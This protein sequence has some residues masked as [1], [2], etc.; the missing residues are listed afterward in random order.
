MPA[1]NS[2]KFISESIESV[3]NQ[4]YIFWELIVVDDGSTDRTGQIIQSYIKQ[5]SRIKYFFQ[6]N[7]KQGKARNLGLKFAQGELIAFIDSDDIWLKSKLEI[8]LLEIKMTNSTMVFSRSFCF[9]SSEY[10]FENVFGDYVGYMKGR[11]GTTVLLERNRIPILSVLVRKDALLEVGGFS[12]DF[13]ISNAEDYHLWLKLILNNKIFYGS[14]RILC[15]YR[16][17]E[18]SVT[19]EDR[20]SKK[21]L[22]FVYYDLKL[23]FPSFQKLINT[24]FK[25]SLIEY[26][27][28]CIY[29]KG[30][31]INIIPLLK[32]SFSSRVKLSIFKLVVNL[33]IGLSKRLLLLFYH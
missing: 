12:E 5:D 1:Y 13:N 3:I 25:T 23:N 17:S 2:E 22:P 19:K 31:L 6:K 10:N 4:S 24:R 8:Q 20:L 33:P 7:G 32:T 27:N 9:K 14:N 30:D 16:L 28:N 15:S 29:N 21:Q 11:S 18:N 26:F